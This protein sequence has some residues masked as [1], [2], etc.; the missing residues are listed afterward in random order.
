MAKLSS[1]AHQEIYSRSK[2][3][4]KQLWH[5]TTYLHTTELENKND[6]MRRSFNKKHN[7]RKNKV[8]QIVFLWREDWIVGEQSLLGVGW[9][10]FSSQSKVI[11]SEVLSTGRVLI[12]GLLC[13]FHWMCERLNTNDETLKLL[14]FSNSSNYCTQITFKTAKIIISFFLKKSRQFIEKKDFVFSP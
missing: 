10:F 1:T 12:L 13:P 5:A 2:V 8:H 4:I 6:L 11:Y 9:V 7:Q 3:I 14:I